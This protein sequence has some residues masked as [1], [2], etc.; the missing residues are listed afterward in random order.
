MKTTYDTEICV[1]FLS[2]LIIKTK[3]KTNKTSQFREHGYLHTT[4]LTV[5]MVFCRKN[6]TCNV[7]TKF[8]I[9]KNKTKQN[10][11]KNKTGNVIMT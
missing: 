3:T 1:Y 2:L 6:D 8:K 4:Y 5:N 10:K 11:S 7:F 9:I